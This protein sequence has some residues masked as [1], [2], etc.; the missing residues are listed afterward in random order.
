[1]RQKMDWKNRVVKLLF[2][3]VIS[4]NERFKGRHNGE[5]CY[6][7]GNGASLKNMDLSAFADRVTI[8]LNFLCVHRDFHRLN[9][10]Y[11][12]MPAPKF[13]YPFYENPYLKKYQRNPTGMALRRAIAKFPKTTVFT[14][15]TNIASLA[16]VRE[17]FY[18]HHFGNKE[19]DREL[20]D[21]SG[22][23]SFM[24]GG[25][26]GGIGVA[27]N[28]GFK[29][30]V[31]IG[32]DYVFT[33]KQDGHFYGA[34]PAT[35]SDQRGN[36]YAKLFKEAGE[37]IELSLVTD[38]GGSEWLPSEEYEAYTGRKIQYREN[39]EIVDGAYLKALDRAYRQGMYNTPIF[40][41]QKEGRSA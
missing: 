7:V 40:H 9:A 32:C 16:M 24:A 38:T 26:Y 8:G 13:L 12:V 1:M 14:S 21:I 28:L 22:V 6:I 18:V 35:R 10:L 23:F 2:R 19:P 31:L 30:A 33:P 39:H 37:E 25:L 27:I 36:I 34:G 15:I 17:A 3:R 4:R 41:T 20:C 11:Y 29:K 5:T